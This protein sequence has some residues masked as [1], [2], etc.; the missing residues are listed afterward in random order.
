MPN[1]CTSIVKICPDLVWKFLKTLFLLQTHTICTSNESSNNTELKFEIKKFFLLKNFGK[2]GKKY[3]FSID[4]FWKKILKREFFENFFLQPQIFFSPSNS[5]HQKTNLHWGLILLGA[6]GGRWQASKHGA[7]W[8]NPPPAPFM[9]KG[10]GAWNWSY[11][12][13]YHWI[14]ENLAFSMAMDA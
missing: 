8:F 2:K 9:V 14:F 6:S 1:L 12:L 13:R 11:R 3:F 5:K 4:N 10:F 7:S